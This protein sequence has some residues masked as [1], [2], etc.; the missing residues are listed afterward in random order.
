MFEL[1]TDQAESDRAYRHW[2]DALL[3]V[4]EPE[5]YGWIIEGTG[6]VFSNYGHG[7]PGT[8]KDQVMLGA[9]PEFDS[10][11]VKIVQPTTAQG[12][13]GKLTAIGRDE[14]GTLV[15]LRQGWLKANRLSKAVRENFAELTGLTP[16]GV[17]VAG[18][19]SN[20]AWYIVA[21]LNRN[22]AE[23]V[24]QTVRFTLACTRARSAAGGGVSRE[25]S[26]NNF[27]F[28]LDEKGRTTKV[29][30]TGGTSE[31]CALQGYVWQAL[32]KKI[33]GR[34]SKP[35]KS[36]FA[37]DG[38][39]ASANL[40]LEIKTG[41]TPDDVYTGTGQLKLYPTIIGLDAD[42]DPILLVPDSPPLKP[43]LA[44]ALAANGIEVYTYSVGKLGK[45]PKIEFS[46]AFLARCRDDAKHK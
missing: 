21:H 42:L 43:A 15:L 7:E 4:G 45:R 28:G 35:G 9:D 5:N 1:L 39:I 44:A 36:G 6:V 34:L 37:V 18:A 3:E 13:K 8:V 10:G 26:Q 16:V 17:T 19:P 41:T 25:T 14:A 40:V 33:G 24:A 23:I 30:R 32:K 38:L 20:R 2:A 29:T 22:A 46:E 31:A 11:V 12:E 27:S